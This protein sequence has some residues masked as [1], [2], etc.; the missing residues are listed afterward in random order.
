[1]KDKVELTQSEWERLQRILACEN[2]GK[3]RNLAIGLFVSS[4]F[5][6]IG[7]PFLFGGEILDFIHAIPWAMMLFFIGMA[8]LGYYKLFR[9]IHYLADQCDIRQD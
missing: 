8:R 3:Q 4:G 1:M 6:L 5:F 2:L 7:L 9:L